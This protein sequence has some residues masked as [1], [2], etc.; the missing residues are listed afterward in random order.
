MVSKSIIAI[1]AT[2]LFIVASTLFASAACTGVKCRCAVQVSGPSAYNPQ[3]DRWQ[4]GEA[5]KSALYSCVA[6]KGAEAPA[7]S[8]QKALERPQPEPRKKLARPQPQLELQTKQTRPQPQ[9]ETTHHAIRRNIPHPSAE[10]NAT[11]K[12]EIRF[13]WEP[14]RTAPVP[15]L[16]SFRFPDPYD[17][18]R[19]RGRPH[20]LGN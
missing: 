16:I 17:V 9:P 2:A 14:V 18:G 7:A 13:E 6:K 12:V 10:P 3:T 4:V 1:S 15:G 11:P 20:G 19:G 8:P 5:Y